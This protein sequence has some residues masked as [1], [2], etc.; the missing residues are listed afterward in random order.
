VY[1]TLTLSA[2]IFFFLVVICPSSKTSKA[3]ISSFLHFSVVPPCFSAKIGKDEI[4][5]YSKYI[6]HKCVTNSIIIKLAIQIPKR[7]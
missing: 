1:A 7:E 2:S 4:L 3:H 5:V 6:Q